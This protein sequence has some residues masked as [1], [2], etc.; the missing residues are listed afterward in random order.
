MTCAS[1][2]F[3]KPGAIGRAGL[4]AGAVEAKPLRASAE[5]VTW[6]LKVAEDDVTSFSE[7]FVDVVT[8]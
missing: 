6:A 7:N 2:S 8:Q 4:M 5:G 3:D 1:K